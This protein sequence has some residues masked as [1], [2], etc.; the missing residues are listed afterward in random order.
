MNGLGGLPLPFGER[1]GVRGQ[2]GWTKAHL[3]C[4]RKEGGDVPCARSANFEDHAS[5]SRLRRYL[6]FPER[7]GTRDIAALARL[8]A[9]LGVEEFDLAANRELMCLHLHG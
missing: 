7:P 5:V 1:V 4:L 2:P 8:F 9:L 6:M 3:G